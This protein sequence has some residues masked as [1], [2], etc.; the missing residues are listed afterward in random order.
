M[1]SQ[2]TAGNPEFVADT[3]SRDDVV[4]DRS[5]ASVVGAAIADAMGWITEFMRSPSSLENLLGV[6]WIDKYVSWPKRTGGRFST[7][8]DQINAGDYSDD[9]QLSL[10][11]ARSVEPD[12]RFKPQ[13]FM[14]VELALWTQY[15]RGA[16]STITAASRAAQRRSTT[17]ESNFFKYTRG[18]RTLD[19]RD[20]GANGAAMRVGPL[21]VANPRDPEQLCVE[22]WKNTVVT[23]GHPR[24]IVGAL[25]IGEALRR[26]LVQESMSSRDFLPALI[27]FANEIDVPE[28]DGFQSW[29]HRWNRDGRDFITE[30][31]EV[32]I[33]AVDATKRAGD[34]RE[35][36]IEEILE[37]LG[38]FARETRGS[39]V[40][41]S[42][43]AIALFYRY[44]GNFKACVEHAVNMIGSDTDTIGAMAAV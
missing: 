31:S 32:K 33:E 10:C 41:T 38:C 6:K 34:A 7:Y 13:Y 28:V 42:V 21:A 35:V 18:T 43:A 39:G 36:A 19:Y 24:A 1:V 2:S 3:P 14:K 17:W 26:V 9:T 15:A 12:G 8:V 29:L 44:G 23:H 25:L 4:L 16:G 22:V 5:V 27:D 37:D 40:G 30:L 11:V 20:S